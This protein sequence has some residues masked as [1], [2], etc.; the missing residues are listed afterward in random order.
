MHE[1]NPVHIH[2]EIAS[3]LS[4]SQHIPN[5]SNWLHEFWL[6]IN[7]VSGDLC[8]EL[9]VPECMIRYAKVFTAGFHKPITNLSSFFQDTGKCGIGL[10]GFETSNLTYLEKTQEKMIIYCMHTQNLENQ[11]DFNMHL[12]IK[13]SEICC[14]S[15]IHVTLRT[16]YTI[17]T[18]STRCHEYP[19]LYWSIK[20]VSVSTMPNIY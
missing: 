1:N 17:A 8:I 16:M 13:T 9:C 20:L 2:I 6:S 19:R 15:H 4:L 3:S 18:S 7:T 5:V 11:W 12:C 14:M 10:H